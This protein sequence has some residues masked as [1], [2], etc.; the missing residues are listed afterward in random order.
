MPDQDARP[1]P[2]LRERKKQLTRRTIAD[3]AFALAVERGL[4]GVTIDTIAE[5]A[6]VSPRTVSN[7]FP[8]KE[9]A[10]VA[11]GADDPEPIAAALVLEPGEAPLV[12]IREALA[13][14]VREWDAEHLATLRAKEELIDRFPAL[15]PHRMAQYD[16][17]EDALR[18]AVAAR[19]GAD[20]D[21]DT[22]P[23]LVAGAGAAVLKTAIRIWV[24]QG[25]DGAELA[26]LVERGFDEVEGGLGGDA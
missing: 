12:A 6:F 11:S 21:T 7:Y 14:R 3:A 2:G 17:L 8:S 13:A 23:R 16:A 22:L 15:L 1:T 26:A 19:L 5:Q 9:A 20:P 4:D 18:V 24:Q 10:I 25:G